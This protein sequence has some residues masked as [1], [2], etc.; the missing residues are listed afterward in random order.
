ML[1]RLLL[2][3]AAGYVL[4]AYGPLAW[5]SLTLRWSALDNREL[6]A[7]AGGA[8]VLISTSTCPWCQQARSWL[9]AQHVDHIDCVV[10]QL[11]AGREVI[12]AAGSDRVPQLILAEERVYGFEADA[13]ARALQTPVTAPDSNPE[14]ACERVRID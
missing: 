7:R 3:A 5:Q 13:Y 1:L 4:G 11:P 12:A 6:I 10:D 2:L 14:W 8:P 9:R